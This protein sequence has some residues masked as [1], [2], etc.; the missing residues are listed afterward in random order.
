MVL[1]KGLLHIRDFSF[2][3]DTR[4]QTEWTKKEMCT[5]LKISTL[6][7]PIE[8]QRTCE[9]ERTVNRSSYDAHR[10]KNTHKHTTISNWKYIK[11]IKTKSSARRAEI[12]RETTKGQ[13]NLFNHFRK[14]LLFK[15]FYS[16]IIV[17]FCSNKFTLSLYVHYTKRKFY[18]RSKRNWRNI[19]KI[20]SHTTNDHQTIVNCFLCMV[21]CRKTI[22]SDD[23]VFFSLS[24]VESM[25]W[26]CVSFEDFLL[27]HFRSDFFIHVVSNV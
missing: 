2:T 25:I 26:L 15:S 3:R 1:S 10:K 7:F 8:A 22:A 18:L 12:N 14:W 19:E 21:K 11:R 16:E 27:F 4:K 17:W 9:V 5:I 20:N 6:W 23:A 13:V 24:S